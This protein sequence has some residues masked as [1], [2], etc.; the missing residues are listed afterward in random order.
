ME[1]KNEECA[2]AFFF[3]LPGTP[4]SPVLEQA[5]LVILRNV[6]ESPCSPVLEHRGDLT[7]GPE[8]RCLEREDTEEREEV[9]RACT[10]RSAVG[11]IAGHV[12]AP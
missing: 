8:D 4:C 12:A 6:E 1:E 3:V 10:A 11:P 5:V 2:P 9:V 7:D